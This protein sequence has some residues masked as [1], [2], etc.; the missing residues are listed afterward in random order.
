SRSGAAPAPLFARSPSRRGP[1]TREMGGPD[2][3]PHTPH[4]SGRPGEAVAPLDTP[5]GSEQM[6]GPDMA[7]QVLQAKGATP[8]SD[9]PG[10]TLGA[11]RRS[12]GTPRYSDRLLAASIVRRRSA[13]PRGPRRGRTARGRGRR[14]PW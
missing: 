11:P 2:M 13:A 12:R 9:S 5:T 8:P 10:H 1:R 3:A 7:P 4:R 14:R 6:G